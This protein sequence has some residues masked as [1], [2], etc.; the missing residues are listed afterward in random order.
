[1]PNLTKIKKIEISRKLKDEIVAADLVFVAFD[2]LEFGKIQELRDKL[3]Q[4]DATFRVVRNSILFYASKEAGIISETKRPDFLKG[5]TAIIIVKNPDEISKVSK[6]IIDF[7]KENPNLRIKAGILSKDFVTPDV[8]KQISRLG[9][10]KELTARVAGSLYSLMANIRS[11]IEAPIRDL[12]Y[13]LE[14]VK[15][16]KEKGN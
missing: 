12:V 11:V 8:I 4:C 5:P 16:K 10:K 7:S 2:K 15:D 13:A 3:K 1:M 14:A 6:T 9:S